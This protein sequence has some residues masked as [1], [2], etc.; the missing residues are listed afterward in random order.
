MIMGQTMEVMLPINIEVVDGAAHRPELFEVDFSA[1][2]RPGFKPQ[3]G[4]EEHVLLY[5][6]IST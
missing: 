6:F 1:L 3:E 2:D 5:N 4:Q